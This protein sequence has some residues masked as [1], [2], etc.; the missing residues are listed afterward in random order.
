MF[1][2]NLKSVRRVLKKSVTLMVIPHFSRFSTRK[3]K[4]TLSF[5]ISMAGLWTF[6]TLLAGYIVGRNIDYH[7][8][9]LD[10]RILKT[11]VAFIAE[12]LNA[13]MKSL[14]MTKQAD[15][16]LR[17]LLAMKSR[18]TIAKSNGIGGA[19]FDDSMNFK[20][21]IAKKA[22]EISE[23][24]FSSNIDYINREA[25]TALASYQ[26]ITWYIANEQNIYK[27]TPSVWPTSGRVTSSFGYRIITIDG[28]TSGEF[29]EGI[30]IA[31]A[32]N[33]PIYASAEGRVRIAG[34]A[35]GYGR[36]ILIDHGFG[37]STFYGHTTE[38]I[39]KPGDYVKR[40]QMIGRMGTT[41]RSK[42]THL[43]YEVWN[44]GKEQNPMRYLKV[45]NLKH[46]DADLRNQLS[47]IDEK[48]GNKLS[49]LF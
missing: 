20:E 49:G 17:K 6:V 11:K 8:T 4:F 15:N 31:N 14:D 19:S 7:A 40:G 3:F 33:T 24:L 30:D 9:N 26:D 41:G 21:V 44:Y 22:S 42:G 38:I 2:I 47:K 35:K 36:A 32:P 37:F 27:A 12:K 5:I 18:D 16:K 1:N 25:Q 34:F 46:K 43:H 48:F 13:S 23:K 29:H 39:V 10:N 28:K 45:G